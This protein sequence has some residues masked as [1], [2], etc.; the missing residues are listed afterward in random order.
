MNHPIVIT[1]SRRIGNSNMSVRP[2][3][4]YQGIARRALQIAN[5]IFD[6]NLVIITSDRQVV[7][8]GPY[9]G[10]GFIK[11]QIAFLPHTTYVHKYHVVNR[12]Q[13]PCPACAHGIPTVKRK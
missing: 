8:G 1:S 6:D 2:S 10:T 3:L 5:K 7:E 12:T 9:S 11:G 13:N 4:P